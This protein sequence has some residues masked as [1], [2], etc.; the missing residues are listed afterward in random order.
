[1]SLCNISYTESVRGPHNNRLRAACGPRASAWTTLN[2]LILQSFKSHPLCNTYFYG[3]RGRQTQ[4]PPRAAN[5]LATPLLRL[6]T[7]PQSW[8]KQWFPTISGFRH[9]TKKKY[10]LRQLVVV[11]YN[12]QCSTGNKEA[13]LAKRGSSYCF[14]YRNFPS[15]GCAS[16]KRDRHNGSTV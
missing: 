16:P 4:G 6:L 9:L 2:W 3:L 11:A 1:M 13:Y 10:N 14:C 5:T 12:E 7:T 8:L 15:P